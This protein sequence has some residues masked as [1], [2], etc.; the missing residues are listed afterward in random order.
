[1]K[2]C[3]VKDIICY[4]LLAC[5]FAIVT[6][7]VVVKKELAFDNFFYNLIMFK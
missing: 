1:M 4:L 5:A 3:S 2:K 6:V 7:N